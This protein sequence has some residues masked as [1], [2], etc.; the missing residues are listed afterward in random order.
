MKEEADPSQSFQAAR[1]RLS[2]RPAVQSTCAAQPAPIVPA[3]CGPRMGWEP[4][5]PL[6]SPGFPSRSVRTRIDPFIRGWRRPRQFRDKKASDGPPARRWGLAKKSAF[7]NRF[8]AA[9][10][11]PL[12]NT[13]AGCRVSRAVVPTFIGE[14]PALVSAQQQ[15]IAVFA[16]VK[17]GSGRKRA[18][19]FPHP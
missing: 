4:G 11:G 10:W 8:F 9:K 14:R 17:N 12:A 18:D 19:F 2:S 6:R 7:P 5:V 3:R 13:R 1:L 16:R 15:T